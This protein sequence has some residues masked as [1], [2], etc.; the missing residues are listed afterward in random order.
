MASDEEGAA[1]SQELAELKAW[2]ERR[3]AELTAE[4]ERLRAVVRYVD[5]LL[6]ESSFK[7]ADTLIAKRAPEQQLRPP[8]PEERPSLRTIR[9]RSGTTLATVTFTQDA[10]RFVL[11]PDLVV[12]RD[13]RPFS[14]FLLRKVL[15][16]YV[17][18]DM[19]L[20]SRGLLD[21]SLAF[22]Y[23]VIYEGDRVKEIEVRNYRDESRLRE[24]INAVRWTLE[25]ALA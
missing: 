14:S 10:A 15:E 20:V 5:E 7:R 12:T 18:Q 9:S 23:E 1:R 24:I 16:G 6:A 11:N 19:D 17:N 13:H 4:L 22:S 25:T 21:S 3:I 8:Q 2:L